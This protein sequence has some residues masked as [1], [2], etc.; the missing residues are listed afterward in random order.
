MTQRNEQVKAV[1]LSA[2]MVLSVIAIGGA[3]FAGTVAA[4]SAGAV[5][6]DGGAAGV[7]AAP[8]DTNVTAQEITFTDGADT[9]GPLNVTNA[10]ISLDTGSADEIEQ[11][12]LYNGSQQ[13]GTGNVNEVIEFTSNV[14]ANDGGNAVTLTV[15][16]D[17]NDSAGVGPT[18][19][20]K[21]E[22]VQVG[23]VDGNGPATVY[24]ESVTGVVAT[25]AIS[26]N[27]G[28]LSVD[29]FDQASADEVVNVN[30][31]ITTPASATGVNETSITLSADNT[32]GLGDQDLLLVKNGQL[33]NNVTDVN[34]NF[35]DN[36]NVTIDVDAELPEDVS[37]SDNEYRLDLEADVTDDGGN[38]VTTTAT[39][40]GSTTTEV[41]MNP[42]K[43]EVTPDEAV[44]ANADGD[45]A[46]ADENA[47][48]NVSVV[49][50]FG[51]EI[52]DPN[53]VDAT[54]SLTSNDNSVSI[55][56]ISDT[57]AALG[58]RKAAAGGT[59]AP[60][61][62]GVENTEVEDVTLNAFDTDSSDTSL[63][64]GS[65]VQTFV[66]QIAGVNVT[67]NKSTL[68]AD[69]NT[70]AEA[71]LQLVD[72]NGNAVNKAGVSTSFAFNNGSAAG[73]TTT[74]TQS[75]TTD[76]SGLATVSFTA[77]N[78]D[79]IIESTGLEQQTANQYSDNAQLT[80]VAGDVDSSN[81]KFYLNGNEVIGT[82]QDTSSVKVN[83][84]HDVAVEVQD[85]SGNAIDGRT[86]SYTLNGSQIA[87]PTS[88]T[89]GFA[90]A[91]ITLPTTKGLNVLNA[92]VGDFNASTTTDAQVN[93]T[94]TAENASALNFDSSSAI[95]IAPN[96]QDNEVK[97]NVVDQFDNI[98]TTVG[99]T[100][101]LT[102]SDA[103]IVDFDSSASDSG[104]LSS[105]SVTFNADANG[106]G[107][108]TLSAT[109]SDANITNASQQIT[110]ANPDAIEV[111]AAHNVATSST[112][113]QNT[114]TQAELEATFVDA[115]GDALGINGENISFA[116]QSGSAAEL[117]QSSSFTKQTDANGNVT[118]DVNGTS[119]TGTTTFI[120]IA[121]NFSVSG[122][123]DVETTGATDSI[124]LTPDS[125]SVT[126]GDSVNLSASFVDSQGR[127]VPRTQSLQLSAADGTIESPNS[128]TTAFNDNGR[129]VADFVF[130]STNAAAGDVTITAIGGGESG[131]TTVSVGSTAGAADFQVSNVQPDGANVTQGDL[132]NVTADVENIGGQ[133]GTQTVGFRLD[134]NTDGSLDASEELV[135]KSVQIDAGNSTTVEFT[136]ID[137][138]VLPNSTVTYDHGVFSQDD[139]ATATITVE[140]QTPTQGPG[141]LTGD[142]NAAQD[143]DGDGLFEDV[144]G[145]N[146]VD[147]QDLRP[148]FDYV[149]ANNAYESGL[150]FS[151]DGSL[152]LQ[153]LRPFFDEVTN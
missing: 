54:V 117:N 103:S 41:E 17:L 80:T 28:S 43:L 139:N 33:T 15:T 50:K 97:I 106:T 62:F 53:D 59:G 22:L 138:S 7:T 65:G 86:V 44:F 26:Y 107:T 149:T 91:T 124:S 126:Q 108:V 57:S 6:S 16:A 89:D 136:N 56:N 71:R 30:V 18:D 88:N 32:P 134:T 121:E 143:P 140:A 128:K 147:L 78:K 104:S 72:S 5:A 9:N 2:L 144:N 141:D 68:V 70:A 92:S 3:G 37:G 120:A 4:D 96:S 151:N 114:R 93:I 58:V 125:T 131:S 25:N 90:N 115:N 77:T 132:I 67:M 127:I 60:I 129:A 112:T 24:N 83:T 113:Q 27:T 12:Y 105:G 148:F 14:T 74:S 36:G 152:D 153:D 10:T 47:T 64:S 61:Q 46:A 81:T 101:T 94:S 19:T 21:T 51:N 99:D 48:V 142:G 79:V 119:S 100:V 133:D 118:I 111:T 122:T 42:A 98:N 69:G 130:N 76:S 66:G 75:P 110:V 1:I 35:D 84:D 95:S 31:S 13:V 49:D 73:L 85:G 63:N 8:G 38:V 137:T 11:L 52:S 34:T 82:N 45:T 55:T 145:D 135:N 20:I 109:T 146:N 123:V 116:R 39:A 150:D 87:S 40:L 29:T 102:S 23:S